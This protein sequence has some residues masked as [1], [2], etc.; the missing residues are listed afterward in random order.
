[1][2]LSV[3]NARQRQVLKLRYGL[4]GSVPCSFQ[5]IA[6]EMGISKERARQIDHEA[7]E[8]LK[9]AGADFGLEDFLGD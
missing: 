8:K 1:M 9:K 3:L 6:K 4:D 7:L 2:L 5:T